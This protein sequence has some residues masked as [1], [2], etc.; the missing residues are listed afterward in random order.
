MSLEFLGKEVSQTT[1]SASV[2]LVAFPRVRQGSGVALFDRCSGLP[3]TPGRAC[4]G[5]AHAALSSKAVFVFL[6]WC[7]SGDVVGGRELGALLPDKLRAP[8]I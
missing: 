7:L 3:L 4:L 1:G 5:F 6:R 2:G 8:V